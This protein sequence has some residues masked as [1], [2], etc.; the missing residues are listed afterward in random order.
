[1]PYNFLRQGIV[2]FEKSL[3]LL[4]RL[5]FVF[6]RAIMVAQ[7]NIAFER[8]PGGMMINGQLVL[9]SRKKKAQPDG[10][11]P[12]PSPMSPA[13]DKPSGEIVKP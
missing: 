2:P 13:T 5:R 9:I 10:T 12:P 4:D 1:M 8:D 7:V 11:V 3:G 6:G